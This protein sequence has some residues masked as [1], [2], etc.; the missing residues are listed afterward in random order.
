MGVVGDTH[1]PRFGRRLPAA[2]LE[3]LRGAAVELILHAGDLTSA[4][5][6]DELASVAPVV[7]VAGNNDPPEL[8]DRLGTARIL[9]ID[10]VRVGLTHGHAGSG[11]RTPDRALATFA[12]ESVD[13]VVFG[14]SHVPGWERRD[15]VGLLNPGSP[16][17]RRRMPAY[18]Y[19][20]LDVSPLERD[21]GSLLPA[22]R[23]DARIVWFSDRTPPT[24]DL[25]ASGPGGPTAT[26]ALGA[27]S[28][29]RGPSGRR[30]RGRG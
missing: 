11:A 8:V 2:L 10:G 7:A 13:V 3:G 20:I 14:H 5:V 12:G 23:I 15:G 22:D 26:R 1:L 21:G 28:S 29:R 25:T 18:S 17:D 9:E 4:G 19:A 30:R 16:T 24:P 6:L 27:R